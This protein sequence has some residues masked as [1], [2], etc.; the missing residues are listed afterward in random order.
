MG[1]QGPG[2]PYG[3]EV[4]ED[5][6][7]AARWRRH[8]SLPCCPLPLQAASRHAGKEIASVVI[9]A[10]PACEMAVNLLALVQ[11]LWERVG[12]ISHNSQFHTTGELYLGHKSIHDC[13][14]SLF[15]P[16]FWSL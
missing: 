6:R 14:H 4:G 16:A 2:L 13:S 15:S 5:K 1:D 10:W 12:L 9:D 7:W 3:C 11:H 8:F